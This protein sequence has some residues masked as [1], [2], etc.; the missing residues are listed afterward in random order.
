MENS[1]TIGRRELCRTA[2]A[3]S[4]LLA[5]PGGLSLA[6]SGSSAHQLDPDRPEDLLRAHVKM[7]YSL[8]PELNIGW[9]RGKRFAVS[10]GRVEPLCGM[11]AATLSR[12]HKVSEHEY[13]F[14]VLEVTVYTDLETG[15]LLDT[16]VMPF[17]GEEV[18]IPVHRFGPVP[19]RFA[20][21]LDETEH[22]TPKPGTTQAQFATAGTVSMT[23][24]IE[25]DHER[26]GN[27]Y[28]RHE[29]YGRRYPEGSDIP[30][31]FYRE[32]TLWSAPT[33][34]VLD[35]QID[36]VA[37]HVNYSAMTSWRPY[38][39]MGDIPGHT[40]S[41]GFGGR[42]RSIDELPADYRDIVNRVHPDVLRDPE[43]A[44][45]PPAAS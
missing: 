34:Q 7:R 3:C 39:K 25:R 40:F 36:S 17:S 2:L 35:P 9:L 27:L 22:Y 28:L 19:V 1:N 45:G 12:L 41:N 16:L 14:T 42:A 11:L 43:G 38:M 30:S 37:S 10:E 13:E 33:A 44:L 6:A 21:A 29:E 15:E 23:K 5:V 18:E 8:G 20:V 4:G 26:D 32:T 24:S 31:L